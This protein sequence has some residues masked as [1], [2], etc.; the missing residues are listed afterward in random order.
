M[1]TTH[2]RA[3]TR[4]STLHI[5]VQANTRRSGGGA[6]SAC[7]HRESQYR[8]CALV[9]SL[10]QRGGGGKQVFCLQPFPSHRGWQIPLGALHRNVQTHSDTEPGAL[11]PPPPPPAR[12]LCTA[13]SMPECATC[14]RPWLSPAECCAKGHHQAGYVDRQPLSQVFV[15]HG[16]PPCPRC[17]LMHRGVRHCCSRGHHKVCT[18]VPTRKRPA[19]LPVG[20]CKRPCLKST[21]PAQH[22][23]FLHY[24]QIATPPAPKRRRPVPPSPPAPHDMALDVDSDVVRPLLSLG[25]GRASSEQV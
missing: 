24:R 22:S 18:P 16:L 7:A 12:T 2:A 17:M 11:S 9:L 1:D 4:T 6:H 19:P 3:S 23:H 13:H 21:G 10:R 14:K 20:H 8:N 15:A 25:H 5:S